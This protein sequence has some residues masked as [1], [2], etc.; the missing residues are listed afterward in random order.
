[1][2]VFISV[3]ALG[4]VV[5]CFGLSIKSWPI[6]LLGRAIFGCGETS[7]SVANSAI[8]AEWF[9]DKE[10]AF[11]FGFNLSI[12]RMGSVS[13]NSVSPVLALI[14]GVVLAAWFGAFLLGLGVVSV[15]IMIP[16]DATAEASLKQDE[17]SEDV[18]ESPFNSGA[19]ESL[20]S[21]ERRSSD[22]CKLT[23]GIE[24]RKETNPHDSAPK[25]DVS[26]SNVFK[27][28][29]PYWMLT[30]SCL[31]IYGE[32]IQYIHHFTNLIFNTQA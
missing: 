15:L 18:S 19:H 11:A 25:S 10:L 7:N 23:S 8:V 4:Q 21:Y 13:S 27:F 24:K 5:F 29:F 6:M 1:L 32:L 9:E 12:A 31:L 2:L 28:R 22:A 16:I 20:L 26:L 14:G 3:I 17:K 30:A